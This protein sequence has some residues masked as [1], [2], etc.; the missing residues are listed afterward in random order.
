[1]EIKG[2]GILLIG[3]VRKNDTL[4]EKKVFSTGLYD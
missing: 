4:E 1:V 2:L 3:R